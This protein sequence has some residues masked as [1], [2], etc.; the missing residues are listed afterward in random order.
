MTGTDLCVNKPHK[1]RSY[2]NH[3]VLSHVFLTK[4]IICVKHFS[5]WCINLILNKVFLT[6]LKYLSSYFEA[7][8]V[9]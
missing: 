6:A 1:S 9:F 5:S 8:S 4:M 2:L 7:G 3:L